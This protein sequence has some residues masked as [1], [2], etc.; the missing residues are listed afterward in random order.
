MEIFRYSETEEV[1]SI[2]DP[3][4]DILNWIT[5]LTSEEYLKTLLRKTHQVR[6]EILKLNIFKDHIN[7][8]KI[9][10]ILLSQKKFC[11]K[12]GFNEKPRLGEYTAP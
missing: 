9:N 11:K 1:D 3:F 5:Y 6:K 7:A 12:L 2:L 10:I 4:D 8:R